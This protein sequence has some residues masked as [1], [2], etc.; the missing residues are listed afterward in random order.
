MKPTMVGQT[1]ATQAQ[2]DWQNQPF[3]QSF[4]QN[5]ALAQRTSR[6]WRRVIRESW[7]PKYSDFAPALPFIANERER[8]VACQALAFASGDQRFLSFMTPHFWQAPLNFCKFDHQAARPHQDQQRQERMIEILFRQ[9]KAELEDQAR[10]SLGED[11]RFNTSIIPASLPHVW[12]AISAFEDLLSSEE[13]GTL[14]YVIS[15]DQPLPVIFNMNSKTVSFNAACVTNDEAHII[16]HRICLAYYLRHH[17]LWHLL[18]LSA[19]QI[20]QTI[21]LSESHIMSLHITAECFPDMEQQTSRFRHPTK[22]EFLLDHNLPIYFGKHDLECFQETVRTHILRCQLHTSIDL[23]G[24][25][26]MEYG[27][28][29]FELSA[30]ECRKLYKHNA[31]LRDMVRQTA[32][33]NF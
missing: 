8:L 10:C 2:H 26:Q 19:D 23:I 4:K 9:Y 27:Y 14:H 22:F 11:K 5:L 29:L 6:Y 3:F 1:Y 28:N 33:L 32:F 16:F 20:Y 13:N 15:D 18:T 12:D 24:L 30:H 25:I 7:S 21:G 17:R 31:A